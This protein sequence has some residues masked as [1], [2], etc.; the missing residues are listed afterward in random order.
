MKNRQLE[1]LKRKRSR[2]EKTGNV[3]PIDPITGKDIGADVEL[4][5]IAGRRYHDDTIPLSAEGHHI[6]TDA[7]RDTPGLIPGPVSSLERIARYKIGV[8]L[9]MD[10]IL[11][12]E[13]E[14]AETLLSMARA[15]A[16][17]AIKDAE[18]LKTDGVDTSQHN[19]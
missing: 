19:K 8:I 11:D 9:L 18:N 3:T 10:Q 14:Q 17:L 7:F 12:R 15:Q 2:Y 16:D 4:H 1:R 13:W 5:H 6:I